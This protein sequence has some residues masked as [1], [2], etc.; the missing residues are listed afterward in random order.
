RPRRLARP[1][2]RVPRLRLS[3]SHRRLARRWKGG[4]MD[5]ISSTAATSLWSADRAAGLSELDSLVYRSNLLASDRAIVNFGG[6]NTSAK[7]TEID[8]TGAEIEVLRVKGSGS[9]L[10]T[11]AAPGFTG[12]RLAEILPLA[13]RDAMTD[14]EM[15]EHLGRCQLSPGMPRS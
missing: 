3:R 13:A 5:L 8:H 4:S 15:V 6:G 9:D 11:I 14:E 7:V 10:A 1:G 2:G 12:L